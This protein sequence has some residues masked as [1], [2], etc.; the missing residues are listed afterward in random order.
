M[1]QLLRLRLKAIWDIYVDYKNVHKL[2]YWRKFCQGLFLSEKVTN[3]ISLSF[4]LVK[5]MPL[6]PKEVFPDNVTC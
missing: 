4:N 5:N 2:L 3:F 6:F 1:G